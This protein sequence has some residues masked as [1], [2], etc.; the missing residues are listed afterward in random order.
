M[1]STNVA[2]VQQ[3]I[4]TA[5]NGKSLSA[6]DAYRGAAAQINGNPQFVFY[7][8]NRH[9][10][11]EMGEMIPGQNKDLQ[12]ASAENNLAPSFA[13]GVAKADGLYVESYSPLGTFP[14]LLGLVTAKLGAD[15]ST[16]EQKK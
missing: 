10:L 11:R 5:K 14:N 7:G 16:L 6:S 2:A 1:A 3:I 12:N 4:D 15:H 9:Y 8:S 13:F